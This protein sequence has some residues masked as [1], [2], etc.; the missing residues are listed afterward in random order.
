MLAGFYWGREMDTGSMRKLRRFCL[1]MA[2]AAAVLAFSGCSYLEPRA[3]PPQPGA[4]QVGVY[5]SFPPAERSY[6]LVK[7]VWVDTWASAL[8]VP[9]Y[10]SI[11]AGAADLRN[12]AVALG[13]DA[14]MNFGCYHSDVDPRSDYYCNGNV[15]RYVR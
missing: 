3:M 13:G 14:V 9:R 7:R 1:P 10:A 11:D 12:R 5:E 15:I 8:V 6:V 2:A 4:E